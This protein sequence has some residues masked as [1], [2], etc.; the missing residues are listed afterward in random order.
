M[1]LSYQQ[2]LTAVPLILRAGHVPTIVGDAG[3]GKTALVQ[4]VAQ[5][6]GARLFTTVV[7]LSEK[8]DLAIPIPPMTESAYITTR[9]YGRLLIFNLATPTPSF[10]S[11]NKQNITQSNPFFGFWMNLIVALLRCKVS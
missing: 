2:L 11:F 3:I 1:A 8:G 6:L 10:K 4:A 9:A 7:S 5:Q